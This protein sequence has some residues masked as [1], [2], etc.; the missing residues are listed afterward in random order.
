MYVFLLLLLSPMYLCINLFFIF[1]EINRSITT[2]SSQSGSRKRAKTQNEK[3]SILEETKEKHNE[4]SQLEVESESKGEAKPKST[5]S[6]RKTT[7]KVASKTN[8]KGT[9]KSTR[10]KKVTPV[11]KD[12][13]KEVK[14]EIEEDKVPKENTMC[15]IFLFL[16]VSQ[17][18]GK[19]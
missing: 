3:T 18:A 17:F 13:K 12:P 8:T 4:E 9:S 14:E 11:K 6:A 1:K 2:Q 7:S 15:P 10:G 5:K 16:L 19:F